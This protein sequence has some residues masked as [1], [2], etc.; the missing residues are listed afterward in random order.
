VAGETIYA[1]CDVV[2]MGRGLNM[3]GRCASNEAPS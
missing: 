1:L 3:V 2:S